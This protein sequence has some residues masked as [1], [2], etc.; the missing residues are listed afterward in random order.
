MLNSLM[1]ELLDDF[2]DDLPTEALSNCLTSHLKGH[3]GQPAET[4][5]DL[6]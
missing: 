4:P 1:L 3:Y 5:L 6:N 2:N